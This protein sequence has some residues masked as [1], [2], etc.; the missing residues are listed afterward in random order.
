MPALATA[1]TEQGPDLQKL[2]DFGR[3]LRNR[4]IFKRLG[5]LTEQLGL[6]VGDLPH[7]WRQL[8]SRGYARLDP[9][10]PAVPR[11]SRRWGLQINVEEVELVGWEEA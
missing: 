1:L 3:R 4:T 2:T 10:R 8:L 6:P 5:Y 7:Q 11:Y 9:S